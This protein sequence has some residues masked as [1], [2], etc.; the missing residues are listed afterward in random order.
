MQIYES[1]LANKFAAEA[2]HTSGFSTSLGRD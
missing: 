1:L 2:D